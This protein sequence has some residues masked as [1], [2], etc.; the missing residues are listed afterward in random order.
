LL[1]RPVQYTENRDKYTK[2]SQEIRLSSPADLRLR[3]T[4]GLF[5]QRQTDNIRAEFDLPGLPVYYE[6]PGQQDVYYLSQMQRADRDYAVF[7]DFSFDLTDQLKLNAGIREFWVNNTLTGFFGF[8]D[9]GYSTHSG[10]TLCEDLGNP[11]LTTPGVYTGGDL[12]CSNTDKKVVEH[13][14]T[15]RINLQYQLAP[16]LMVYGTWSTGYR[17]GGNNRLPAAGSFAADTLTNF[18]LGWKTSWLDRRLRANGAVFY[19][20]WKDV[21][22]AVQGQYGITSIVNAGNAKVEGL[23]SE[24]EWAVDDHLN[25]SV[26]GTGLLRVE[27]TS[28]FCKPSPLGA[29]QSTCTGGDIDS[30]PGTQ[31]PV[32]PKIKVNGA[33]RY[34]FNVGEYKSFAQ[35]SVVGQSS[36]SYSLESTAFTVGNSPTFTTVD[37]SAGTALNNWHMEAYIENAFDRRGELGRNSECADKTNYCFLNAHVYPIRPMQFGLKFGQKF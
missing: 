33:A 37:F 30:P 31:L 10:E 8:N 15:H 20:K 3:G 7:G 35:V 23:E 16:A 11:I 36:T 24:I 9:N 5:Y 25:L 17:P 26:A 19:E 29:P 1:D 21:Q 27:T 14:E 2:M 34:G 32:T 22:T 13:G 18:E 6:V 12:P 28:V 4:L